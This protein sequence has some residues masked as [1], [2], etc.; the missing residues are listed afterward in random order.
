[1]SG[2]IET[3]LWLGP[4]ADDATMFMT[5]LAAVAGSI[6]AGWPKAF[7]AP[8]FGHVTPEHGVASSTPFR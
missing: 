7:V 8:G 4:R 3:K 2:L 1:M 6:V 5:R